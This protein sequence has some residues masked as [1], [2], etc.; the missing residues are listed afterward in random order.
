VVDVGDVVNCGAGGRIN[1]TL[2]FDVIYLME[3]VIM[4]EPIPNLLQSSSRY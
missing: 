3:E 2:L 4:G 1:S